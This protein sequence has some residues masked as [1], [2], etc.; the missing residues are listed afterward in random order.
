MFSLEDGLRFVARRGALLQ[1]V[2]G[3]GAMAAVF[4]PPER[5]AAELR[6]HNASADDA[7]LAIAADNGTHQVISGP[8]SAVQAV[9]ERTLRLKMSG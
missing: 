9:S 8:A 5:V 1:A 2:P 7:Q 6:H 4:A 3:S